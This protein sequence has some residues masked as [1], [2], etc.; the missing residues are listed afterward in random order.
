MRSHSPPLRTS[1]VLATICGPEASEDLTVGEFVARLGDRTYGLLFLALAL[2]NFVPAVPGF[3]GVLG[4][5]LI[6]VAVQLVIGR[7]TPW[8]P[9]VIRSRR[10]PK[11]RLQQGLAAAAGVLRRFERI[12]RPRLALFT[13]IL[14]ERILGFIVVYLGAVIALPIPFIGNIP[15]AIAILALALG[16]LER[17]GVVILLGVVLAILAVIVTAGFAATAAVGIANLL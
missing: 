2:A 15:P 1:N 9:R 8:I 16:L 6:L 4:C 7:R 12:C 11:L 13:T 3:S 17:D 10:V 5:I 14:A